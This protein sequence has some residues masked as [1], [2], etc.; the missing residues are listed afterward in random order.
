ML[1]GQHPSKDRR[2]GRDRD[3]QSCGGGDRQQAIYPG[4]NA[5]TDHHI[6]TYERLARF[7]WGPIPWM[8]EIAAILSAILGHWDDLAIILAMLLINAGVSFWQE[9]NADNAIALLKQRLALRARAKR[10]GM[11]RDI[12][13]TQLVPGDLVLVKLGNVVPADLRLVDGTYLSVDQSA[14]IGES[15]PV[16]KKT[17][18]DV[19][20]GSIAKQGEMSGVVTAT[21]MNSYFG[22][23]ARLV[24]Q[25][26]SVSHF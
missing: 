8:I 18:D 4:E 15:L 7:F 20:S 12:P 17:G 5:L 23:T 19:Y 1:Q 9:F 25:A 24:E 26:K 22:K 13:A 10:D 14:L 21:G 6:G 3:C 11:W 2:P 16:D